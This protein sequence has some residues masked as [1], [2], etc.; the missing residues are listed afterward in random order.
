MYRHKASS[1]PDRP[2]QADASTRPPPAAASSNADAVARMAARV[3]QSTGLDLT[4]V[5]VSQGDTGGSD[6]AVVEERILLGPAFGRLGR[7]RQDR[8]L[9]H[10]LAHV[11]QARSGPNETGARD[12]DPEADAERVAEDALSGERTSPAVGLGAG[13]HPYTPATPATGPIAAAAARGWLA[14]GTRDAEG[15][16]L[17]QARLQGLGYRITVVDGV[18]GDQTH[19]AVVAYQRAR[20][21]AADGKVGPV[22]A[23]R[24]DAEGGATRPAPTTPAPTTSGAIA[25]IVAA[26]GSLAMGSR[27]VAGVKAVQARLKELGYAISVVDGLFGR[28]T[29]AAVVRF[30]QDRRVTPYDGVVG[31]LTS[32]ALDQAGSSRPAAPTPAPAPAGPPSPGT[33]GMRSHVDALVAR[34][35]DKSRYDAIYANGA[36]GAALKAYM[37]GARGSSTNA[38]GAYPEAGKGLGF[39]HVKAFLDSGGY[40]RLT[41]REREI[42]QRNVDQLGSFYGRSFDV[43]NGYDWLPSQATANDRYAN[44][45]VKQRDGLVGKWDCSSL[46][47]YVQGRPYADTS[48]LLPASK[49][50]DWAAIAAN[51]LLAAA[52]LPVGTILVRP[53]QGDSGAHTKNVLGHIGTDVL[54]TEAEGSKTLVHAERRAATELA[55]THTAYKA[56]KP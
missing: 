46:S 30:Q 31:R 42:F 9:A 49:P 55:R 47:S 39:D 25:A 29:H 12:V 44:Q 23:A 54:L 3:G 35:G 1:P 22:T 15:T 32:A 2:H 6:A 50:V 56:V 4:D 19:A 20:G 26:Q 43:A 27:N 40:D 34:A 10:E 48:G 51:P 18:F 8:V 17:V 36:D 52:A 21:L 33:A 14:K 53:Q 24:L 28:E 45:Y 11:A 37:E 41:D 16:R 7:A 38:T 5:D 13:V